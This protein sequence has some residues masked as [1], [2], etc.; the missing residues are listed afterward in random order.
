M[1]T[2]APDERAAGPATATLAGEPVGA[3]AH[4][5]LVLGGARSGKSVTA[6]G[7]LAGHARVD[8]VATGAIPEATDAE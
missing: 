7:L 4:R 3:M 6:E 8:Y 5:I 1:A 2:V